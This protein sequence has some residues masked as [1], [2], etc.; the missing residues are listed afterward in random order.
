MTVFELGN[1]AFILDTGIMFPAND[2]LGIDYIIPDFKYL[3]ERKDLKIHGILYTHGHE[4]HVG[5]AQ[6]VVQAFPKVPIW[7]TPLTAGLINVKLAEAQLDKTT[8][9][10]VFQA[11]DIL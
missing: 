2:M 1:D 11:G 3:T 4:D 9:M 10:N 8:T 5:A 7:A 6:H